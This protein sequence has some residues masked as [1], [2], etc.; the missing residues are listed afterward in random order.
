[1]LHNIGV[2]LLPRNSKHS[3]RTA[4]NMHQLRVL[5]PRLQE[6]GHERLA[7]AVELRR[8]VRHSRLAIQQ[9]SGSNPEIVVDSR[10]AGQVFQ[11]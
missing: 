5:V 3:E 2:P 11:T 9:S 7:A 10:V 8:L 1:M 6:L 4:R